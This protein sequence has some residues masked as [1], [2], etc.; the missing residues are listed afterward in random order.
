MTAAYRVASLYQQ[1]LQSLA[2]FIPQPS[3]L[4]PT[5]VELR[6]R[7]HL[8]DQ[9]AHFTEA[10]N[11]VV[12]LCLYMLAYCVVVAK[13]TD[14]HDKRSSQN[15]GSESSGTSSPRRQRR[16]VRRSHIHR[17]SRCGKQGHNVRSCPVP[18]P[19]PM[20]VFPSVSYKRPRSQ[21]RGPPWAWRGPTADEHPA[22]TWYRQ[23]CGRCGEP[24]HNAIT[25]SKLSNLSEKCRVC[26][27]KGR[28]QCGCCAG[29]GYLLPVDAAASSQT[30]LHQEDPLSDFKVSSDLLQNERRGSSLSLTESGAMATA[31]RNETQADFDS[32]PPAEIDSTDHTLTDASKHGRVSSFSTGCSPEHNASDSVV[33][34]SK[35]P[36]ENL[37]LARKARLRARRSVSQTALP[38]HDSELIGESTENIQSSS[39]RYVQMRAEQRSKTLRCP[40][41][42]G[43]GYLSCMA[44][45][46]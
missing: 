25:C 38:G 39:L 31:L 6:R 26:A 23:R 12:P 27:G 8:D 41:C 29:R 30:E 9:R 28:L 4:L 7:G 2:Q 45:N 11:A 34:S 40:R 21:G 22:A 37:D 42:M 15:A 43:L 24:G 33:G 36:Q 13:A 5:E 18:V 14:K 3:C 32:N 1:S 16:R 46:S 35:I 10:E 20:E 44:C 19:K 17:C